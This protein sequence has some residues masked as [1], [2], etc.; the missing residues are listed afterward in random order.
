M[1][2]TIT[3]APGKVQVTVMNETAS[4]TVSEGVTGAD[5]LNIQTAKALEA[6]ARKLRIADVSA[7]E[8]DIQH[9]I[10]DVEDQVNQF[11]ADVGA[12]CQNV[13]AGYH[14]SVE[15]VEHMIIDHPIPSVL[16]AAGLGVLIGM[17][18]FKSRD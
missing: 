16:V 8:E 11:K 15:P 12:R 17:F 3:N 6:A 2:E 18:I 14:K 7:R 4:R 9:I 1:N 13:A 10:Q 5:Q